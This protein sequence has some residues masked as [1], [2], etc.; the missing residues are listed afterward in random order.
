MTENLIGRRIK[1]LRQ[2]RGLSQD[3]VA[4]ML[5]LNDRQVTS[6][7]ETGA[8][9]VSAQELVLAADQLGAPLDYFTDS[10][11]L[12]GEG[13]FS[14]RH[15]GVPADRLKEY[16]CRA[17]GWIGAY[18][19]LAEQT[20]RKAPTV[21]PSLGLTQ[22][23]RPKDAINAGERFAAEF[24]LG[25]VP[26]RRLG[27]VMEDALSILVL[28]VEAGEG[29][30]GAACRLPE[31]DAVLIARRETARRR[32]FELAHELFHILTWEPMPP[33]HVE[34][35]AETGGDHVEQLANSFAAALLMPSDTVARFGSWA[36]L[37]ADGL[38]ARLNE[39]ASALGVTSSALRWRL[40]ALGELPVG[41]ARD[42]PE[43]SLRNNG[44]PVS[45]EATPPAL[46]SKP[47]VEV[48]ETSM[49][50]GLVSTRRA[51]KLVEVSVDEL[52]ELFAAHGV[53][54]EVEL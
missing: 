15:T 14:L 10:F 26:A 42:I 12:D 23:S 32:H 44:E 36:G 38:V 11:R 28:M 39:A 35:A 46:F 27:Q 50:Q 53:E 7:I 9:R 13:Q 45:T 20:G 30:F 33:R 52:P 25:D 29:I 3:D 6:M 8:R 19:T 49:C 24:E 5:G 48:P 16:E 40:V 18:R 1:A 54:H 31:L 47:F 34:E 22:W 51:A 4:R 43:S 37:D 17:G 21:R 2:D 41:M